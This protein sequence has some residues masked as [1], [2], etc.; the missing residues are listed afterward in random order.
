[1]LHIA[2][3]TLKLYI[4]NTEKNSSTNLTNVTYRYNATNGIPLSHDIQ[5]LN[6]KTI[7]IL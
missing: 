3:V 2:M 7:V 6:K 5:F 4:R 1:M